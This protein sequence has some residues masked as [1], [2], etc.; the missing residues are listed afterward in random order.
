MVPSAIHS[1]AADHAKVADEA[2]HAEN[3]NA[4]QGHPASD[5][6]GAGATATNSSKLGGMG[7][8]SF[9]G[10]PV[11]VRTNTEAGPTTGSGT[12]VLWANCDFGESAVGGGFL[13]TGPNANM[14]GLGFGGTYQLR[15]SAPALF[16]EDFPIY[17]TDGQTPTTWLV[18]FTWTGN[19]NN[20][21]VTAYVDCVPNR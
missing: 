1:G 15:G 4:L 21:A 12:A 11:V 8:S 14:S 2:A 7:A 20:P 6:L 16:G 3:S 19:A 17:A 18:V 9:L 13:E 10:G 5:F